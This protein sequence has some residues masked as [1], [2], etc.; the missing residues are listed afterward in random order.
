MTTKRISERTN[1]P[2]KTTLTWYRSNEDRPKTSGAVLSDTGHHVFS[3]W[4]GNYGKWY[5]V[6]SDGG[7]YEITPPKF[8]A[9]IP[10]IDA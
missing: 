10:T 5:A 2:I 8:W 3:D 7:Y 9:Y 6:G 1:E 4:G